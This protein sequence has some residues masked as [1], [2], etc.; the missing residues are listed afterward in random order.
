[1]KIY[2]V[3]RIQWVEYSPA[4]EIVLVTTSREEAI[5][6]ASQTI[7]SYLSEHDV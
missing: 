2:V 7:N 5:N 3:A 4:P 1:M 6:K